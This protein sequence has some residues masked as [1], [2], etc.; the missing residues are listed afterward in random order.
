[1]FI[2]IGNRCRSARGARSAGDARN[3][4]CPPPLLREVHVVS[5]FVAIV[6]AHQLQCRASREVLG[7]THAHVELPSNLPDA[8][9]AEVERGN[10]IDALQVCGRNSCPNGQSAAES[11]REETAEVLVGSAS[12]AE[13]S[14]PAD[15]RALELLQREQR[16]AVETSA[17]LQYAHRERAAAALSRVMRKWHDLKRTKGE[18][19]RL[20]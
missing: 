16:A 11:P 17:G 10:A 14:I 18:P 5:H 1:M 6:H 8:I 20:G 7:D 4:V 19:R 9:T 15:V 3:T 2:A 13:P 12:V